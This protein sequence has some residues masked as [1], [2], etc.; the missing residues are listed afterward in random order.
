VRLDARVEIETNRDDIGASASELIGILGVVARDD[1]GSL[2]PKIE[3]IDSVVYR[4][5][6]TMMVT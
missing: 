6:S 1:S 4:R 2:V 3:V 5:L